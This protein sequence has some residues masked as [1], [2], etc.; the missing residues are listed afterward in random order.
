M[1]RITRVRAGIL[2]LA[3]SIV[4]GLFAFRLYDLQIIETGGKVDNVKY[5]T[6]ETRVKAARGEI[7]DR[8]G[9]VLV[10]NRASYDLVFNHYVICSAEGRN[11]LLLELVQLCREME[12]PY[13]DR[14]PVTKTAPFSYIFDEVGPTWQGYFQKYLPEKGGLDSDI[15]APLLIVKL[16]NHYGIP[17]TWSDTDARA[18][19]GIRY[20]L[21][22]RQGITNLPNYIFLEDA[23]SDAL[24]AILELNTPGL[25]AEATTAREYNTLY[26]AHILGH[27]GSVTADQWENIYKDLEGYAKDTLVGQDGLEEAFESY[28]HGIDGIRVDET[29][30]DGSLRRSYWKTV[31]GV[32]MRPVAGQNVELSID[33]NLQATAED[34]LAALIT[35][36]RQS[37]ENTPEGQAKPDGSDAEGG[38]VVVMD[39]KTGQV[40]ACA[41][42]PTYNLS[43]FREDFS[44]LQNAPYAPL[45][46]R[47]LLA[48]YPPGS[49]YKMSMVIA[50]VNSGAIDRMHSIRDEGVFRKYED[51]NFAPQCLIYTNNGWT[52]GSLNAM[53]ALRDSCN[54][55]FYTLGDMLDISVMDATAKALGLGEKTGV[56]LFEYLG[57][58]SNPE[59]KAQ[60]HDG[61]L[62]RWY[63]ADR[64]M[65]AIGQSENRFTPMQL[66]VYTSTLANRGT[67]YKATFLN[68]VLTAD[69]GTVTLA[70]EPEI[71]S[72]LEISDEAY[73]AYT[74]G[75]RMVATD[76]TAARFFKN[77]PI[78]IAAKTGTAQTDAGDKYS[79]NGAFVC[80][81]PYDDPEIAV[82]VYGEKAGH[83]TT[84]AQIAKELLDT[85]FADRIYGDVIAGENQVS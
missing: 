39:V 82:V 48:T 30:T 42:Y 28:L 10:S 70:N 85:Y 16:R 6:T 31:N 56:E 66:C 23:Q 38:A 4:I 17:D 20:E 59:T 68:R 43:T 79:D 9:N 11:Q 19:I 81:A 84:M 71:L 77:Y 67:R 25:K 27:V 34:Q 73:L 5:Y 80:Y 83:G 26:A 69:Y 57:H 52:H 51:S 74:E 8:N 18:V 49:T 2:L 41:S 22:L 15:S 62:G 7:T 75:M 72:K 32:E 12:I 45:Y 58:R 35:D 63:A 40:L 76:G 3:F 60:L 33:L 1:D 54:Y 46:N 29:Y 14:F 61:D 37:G 65:T 78:A 24:A 50:G 53:E 21:D 47:A 36:L 44:E 13:T 55:Y 64:V